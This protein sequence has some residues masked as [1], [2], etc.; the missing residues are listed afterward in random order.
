[1]SALAYLVAALIAAACVVGVAILRGLLDETDGRARGGAP[2]TGDADQPPTITCRCGRPAAI[3]IQHSRVSQRWQPMCDRCYRHHLEC[4][5]EVNDHEMRNFGGAYGLVEW[6]ERGT[7]G[8]VQDPETGC[9][10]WKGGA[11]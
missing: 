11:E 6:Q 5:Q 3:A 10:S 9:L 1:M 2:M 4:A 8:A 7:A